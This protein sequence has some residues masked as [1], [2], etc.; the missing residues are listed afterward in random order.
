M[1]GELLTKIT[2]SYNTNY[3]EAVN[4]CRLKVANEGVKQLVDGYKDII[5]DKLAI[6][7]VFSGAKLEIAAGKLLA[8][9]WNNTG[10]IRD[11]LLEIQVYNELGDILSEQVGKKMSMYSSF[12]GSHEE[13][14]RVANDLI[15]YTQ[16]LWT[17]RSEGENAFYRLKQN[18]YGANAASLFTL[19]LG[20]IMGFSVDDMAKIDTWYQGQQS[21]FSLAKRLLFSAIDSGLY[22]NLYEYPKTLEKFE[23]VNGR[24]IRYNG[25]DADVYIPYEVDTIAEGA[26]NAEPLT[27][28]VAVRGTVIESRTFV[29]CGRLYNVYIPKSVTDIRENAF[30]NCPQLVINGYRGSAAERYAEANGIPFNALDE[31]SYVSGDAIYADD[32][33]LSGGTLDLDGKTMYVSGDFLHTGGSLYL[34]SGKL[35]IF[36][37]YRIVSEE[38]KTAG[39]NGSLYMRDENGHL[40]VYGDFVTDSRS[41]HS[42]NLTAGILEVKGDFTQ[43]ITVNGSSQNFYATDT[44]KVILSGTGKQTVY[45]TDPD[46]SW[47]NILI[48]KNPD[49]VYPFRISNAKFMGNTNTVS[50]DLGMSEELV[51][52]NGIVI[53]ALYSNEQLIFKTHTVPGEN[54]FFIFTDV[55]QNLGEYTVKA[56]YW[57]DMD[58]LIPLCSETEADVAI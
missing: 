7:S 58:S 3:R 19:T 44:H 34:G 52:E 2:V 48:N 17:V 46:Y 20:K 14:A 21:D 38:G 18:A 42:G 54:L 15:Y 4:A 8:D 49:T 50:A 35:V 27:V 32:Y 23:I 10:E 5:M 33:K 28:N 30:F 51:K 16:L 11:I 56:F 53:F 25:D 31:G 22:E 45:F 37:D 29:N 13:R 36:G 1:S 43:R 57:S 39:S 41:G 26:F 24:L 9:Y 40:T 12:F 6:K 55:P 47:F